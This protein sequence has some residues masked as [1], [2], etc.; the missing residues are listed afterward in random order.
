ME[1]L[2]NNGLDLFLRITTTTGV[3][4]IETEVASWTKPLPLDAELGSLYVSGC[5]ADMTNTPVSRS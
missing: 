1:F 3:Q 4:P 5:L 2:R